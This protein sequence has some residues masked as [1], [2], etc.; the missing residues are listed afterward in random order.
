VIIVLMKLFAISLLIIQAMSITVMYRTEYSNSGLG[1]KIVTAFIYV[2]DP[3]PN[4]TVPLLVLAHCYMGAGNWYDYIAE[5]LVPQGYVVA[6]LDTWSYTPA[7][8]SH[9]EALDQQFLA[10]AVRQESETNLSSPIYKLLNNKTAALGH[11]M[12]GGSTLIVAQSGVFSFDSILTLS[13][14]YEK[15]AAN[16]K[17]PAFIMTGT[18]DCIC[19]PPTN[20]GP[21]YGNMTLSQCKYLVNVTNATHCHFDEVPQ[22]ADD[23]CE[24]VEIKCGPIKTW[25]PREDQWNIVTRYALPWFDFT[26]KD[27][28]SAK[29]HLDSML[30]SDGGNVLSYNTN[31][32]SAD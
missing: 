5:A 21:I 18:D 32:M 24:A 11:S 16:V 8:D 10:Q 26:L 1:S 12:G 2:S 28:A 7:A 19:P 4:G 23:F 31:C 17:V 25:L 22:F 27:S 13:A 14:V 20:A 9:L 6:S 3:P 29:N 15:E 30:N